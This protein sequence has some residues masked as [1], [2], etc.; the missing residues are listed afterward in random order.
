ME[1]VEINNKQ[2]K[3]IIS[4]EWYY[5]IKWIAITCMVIDHIGYYFYSYLNRT[6]YYICREIGRIAFP[7]FCFELALHYINAENKRLRTTFRL[8]L[9][10]IISQVPEQLLEK[11][12]TLKL[13]VCFTLCIAWIM[14]MLLEYIERN[15]NHISKK[16]TELII[17]TIFCCMAFAGFS[18]NACGLILVLTFYLSMKSNRKI[19]WSILSIMLF[20]ITQTVVYGYTLSDTKTLTSLL[21]ELRFVI[22]CFGSIPIIVL[23][24]RNISI[25]IPKVFINKLMQIIARYFYPLHLAL[26]YIIKKL[27]F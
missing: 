18:Y 27:L 15:V 23:S 19:L 20:I 10:A 9:L 21:K 1:S 12:K 17:I 25:K 22:G 7:L 13:N 2:S 16:L 14:L 5:S 4:K 26:I 8:L 6:I 11:T 24:L 3:Y